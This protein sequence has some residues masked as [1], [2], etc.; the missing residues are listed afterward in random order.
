MTKRI[1]RLPE[2]Q[3]TTGLSRSSIYAGAALGTFPSQVPLGARAVGWYEDEVITW[4]EQRAEKAQATAAMNV[5]KA[6]KELG[7]HPDELRRFI[8]SG[9]LPSYRLGRHVLVKKSALSDFMARRQTA[10][11]SHT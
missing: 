5:H 2:V 9:E 11:T 8:E 6:A 4:I 10:K 7:I 3:S 1:I